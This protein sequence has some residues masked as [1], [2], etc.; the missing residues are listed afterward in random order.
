MPLGRYMAAVYSGE[1]L[2]DP[3]FRDPERLLYRVLRVDPE[4]RQDWKQYAKSLIIFSLA[5][6]LL[7][8][9]ILRTQ[10]LWNFTGLNPQKLPLRHVGRDVQHHLVVPHQH[11]LAVLRRRDDDE[12]LQPDGRAHGAELPLGRG[13]D[14]RR[15]RADPRDHRRR[16]GTSIGNF[17]HD[18]VR[19][20][21][22][23]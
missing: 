8:Y 20:C 14:R 2:L 17:W 6:W 7:L 13:R 5:G 9:L 16:S 12:L 4:K 10:T 1:R 18:L 3:L 21:S 23:C 15:R 19:T 22:G 11:E